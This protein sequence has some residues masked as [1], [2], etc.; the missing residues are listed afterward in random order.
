MTCV[1][2][3]TGIRV[4]FSGS[5]VIRRSERSRVATPDD[6][7][8]RPEQIDQVGH[9]IGAHVEHRP[10]AG[11]IVEG[12]VGVPAFVA[13]A[14]EEGGPA[15]RPTDHALVDA[16][17]RGL[18][19]AAEKRVGRAAEP[20]GFASGRLNEAARLGD[21]DAERLFRM[22]ML[23]GGEGPQADLDMRGRHGEVEDDLDGGVGQQGLDRTG[24][25]AELF[26]SRLGCGR[27]RVRQG[28]D[29]ED[30]KALRGL[31]IGGTDVAAA[32]DADA[33]RLHP[34][35]PARGCSRIGAGPVVP[36]GAP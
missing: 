19:R 8:D 31:E 18:V 11:Q 35:S 4:P 22:N 5:L 26:R 20:Q 34:R 16:L 6:A 21:I 15:D 12:G 2:T 32:D 29:V 23:A 24:A 13:G 10:A 7:F 3:W 28:D 14:H 30:G 27:N 17:S 36:Q 25:Q 9:V 33:D 1:A